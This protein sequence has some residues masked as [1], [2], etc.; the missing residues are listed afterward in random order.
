MY[1]L[2]ISAF[3]TNGSLHAKENCLC[4]KN[5]FSKILDHNSYRK[6][7]EAVCFYNESQVLKT[8]AGKSK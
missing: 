2:K 3:E 7:V 4:E 5:Y 8:G 6:F 1:L